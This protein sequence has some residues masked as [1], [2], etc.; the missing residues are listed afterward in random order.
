V[1]LVERIDPPDWEELGETP[2][3]HVS[4]SRSA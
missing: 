2:T 4:L 3:V 1:G